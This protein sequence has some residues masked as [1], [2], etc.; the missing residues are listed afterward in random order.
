MVV[1]VALPP[2][3]LRNVGLVHRDIRWRRSKPPPQ[4]RQLAAPPAY[5][6]AGRDSAPVVGGVNLETLTSVLWSLSGGAQLEW[7]H[8]LSGGRPLRSRRGAVLI[9]GMHSTLTMW[10]FTDGK[11]FQGAKTKICARLIVRGPCS[12]SSSTLIRYAGITFSRMCFV[13]GS[14][15]ENSHAREVWQWAT[16]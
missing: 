9:A 8:F 11:R 4:H 13:G 6:T 12:V 15:L 2:R 3:P 14:R 16:M 7:G 5:S 10:N 1:R